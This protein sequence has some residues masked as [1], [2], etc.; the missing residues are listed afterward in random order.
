[1]SSTERA[2]LGVP[3]G[4]QPPAIREVTTI[5]EPTDK[6]VMAHQEWS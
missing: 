4:K 1:M 6:N 2:S 5:S 3:I